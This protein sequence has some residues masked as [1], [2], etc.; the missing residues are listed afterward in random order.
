[1]AITCPKCGKLNP[2]NARFCWN[3]GEKLVTTG[4]TPFQF[5]KG[6]SANSIED[7]II[8][9]EQNWDESKRYLY[10]DSF[11]T[12][13]SSI[14]RGDLTLAAQDIVQST[15]DE[16]TALRKLIRRLEKNPTF[17]FSDGTKASTIPEF[18]AAIDKNWDEGKRYFYNHDD[19]ADWLE[20][21]QRDD[22]AKIARQ[23]I[24]SESDQD[25]GLEKFLKSVG[26]DAPPNP[27]LSV[28]QTT[29]DWGEVDVEEVSKGNYTMQFTITNSGRGHLYGKISCSESWI[30]VDVKV[31]SGNQIRV[32][33]TIVGLGPPA[34][35][36]I[37]SN[38]GA[39]HIPVHIAPTLELG[40]VGEKD[41]LIPKA[42]EIM[43]AGD[44]EA[45]TS[46]SWLQLESSANS[47][48]VSA[49]PSKA[50]VGRN[51]GSIVISGGTDTTR[52][53]VGLI[54]HA[55]PFY[56]KHRLAIG[57][58]V[59]SAILIALLGYYLW[60]NVIQFN[61]LNTTNNPYLAMKYL[62]SGN[63]L[64]ASRASQA[65]IRIGEPAVGPLIDA[66]ASNNMRKRAKAAVTLEQLGEVAA[67]PLIKVLEH[68]DAE[69][70]KEAV[71]IL[72]RIGDAQIV[73]PLIRFLEHR[74]SE[75]RTTAVEL[76][77]QVGDKRAVEPL[78]E[79]LRQRKVSES[80]VV[81]ALLKLKWRPLYYYQDRVYVKDITGEY[82]EISFNLPKAKG[83]LKDIK[84]EKDANGHHVI[85]AEYDLSYEQS[86]QGKKALLEI[87]NESI[88]DAKVEVT[89]KLINGFGKEISQAVEDL[90]IDAVEQYIDN[91]IE[92]ER[93]G[94]TTVTVSHSGKSYII[95]IDGQFHFVGDLKCPARGKLEFK[96]DAEIG[97]NF[98]WADR[99]GN[100]WGS[101]SPGVI[102]SN[103]ISAGA[104]KA[105]QLGL[106]LGLRFW[107]G[108]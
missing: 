49:K 12:W 11:A 92:R 98:Q 9:I 76:L 54:V 25:I 17:R 23:T 45:R 77:G 78:I 70:R 68:R 4:F 60:V 108:R 100:K 41:S 79:V 40:E 64:H 6:S 42:F 89:A 24:S 86:G 65:L 107:R 102:R 99:R 72:G 82:D 95:P 16:D 14:G 80:Y 63:E 10:S 62:G 39:L 30:E 57:I 104:S 69:V 88:N 34:R 18:V 53:N 32:R 73:E 36:E 29:L 94:I 106:A 38:G 97:L 37:Q 59:V 1:M 84:V 2:D 50:G 21:I 58:G 67:L 56:I 103:K 74:D 27:Q 75:V 43:S 31:F 66:L 28:S 61:R 35:L 48:S 91:L 8:L 93:E 22:L 26:A 44:W 55:A 87:R 90:D 13:F 51:Q 3:D 20:T 81:E 15:K 7:L 105:G 47:I 33:A 46:A 96:T 71:E 19:L 5:T 83:R 101:G 85:K 52:L